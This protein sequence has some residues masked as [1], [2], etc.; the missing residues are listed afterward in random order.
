MATSLSSNHLSFDALL[1]DRA[2]STKNSTVEALLA[3]A[4]RK[5]EGSIAANGAFA[6][7]TGVH[8][9]RS[10]KDK[11][12][13]VD[14]ESRA[15]V[16]WGEINQ[17]M[18]LE[19]F[20]RLGERILAHLKDKEVFVEDLRAGAHP[21]Y[22]L[23][24]RL[25]SE[26]AWH[27][28]FAKQLFIGPENQEVQTPSPDF[29]V[30][31]APGFQ[32]DPLI[33]KVRSKAVI[34]I[35]FRAGLILIGG[36]HYA[37]EI[38]KSIFTV[39]NYLL[40]Q[41]GVLPMHCSANRRLDGE[42]ALFFG[43]SGTGKTTLSADPNRHLIGDDEHGWSDAGIF[44]FEGG[45]YAKCIHLSKEREPQIWNAIRRGAVLE[46]VVL[47]KTSKVPNYDDDSI[48]ENTRAAYPLD[49]IN[50]AVLPSV[51]GHPKNIFFLTAD[52]FGVLPPISRLT[53]E[54]AMYHFLCGYT[55]K[56]AGTESGLGKGPVATFSTCFGAPFLPLRPSQY[57]EM[58]GRR[59]R[60][61]QCECWLVNT[62]WIGG[63]Y[64]VGER[65]SLSYPR[66]LIKAVL[67]GL[68]LCSKFETERV[69]RLS[70][71]KDC[72]EVPSKLLHP[73]Q[74][75][76]DKRAYDR[77]AVALATRFRENAKAVGIPHTFLGGGPVFGFGN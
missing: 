19:V 41:R 75:W 39:L 13:V 71:P 34:A 8:T 49:F 72:P 50:N 1:E 67:S 44:N 17:A 6:A 36:T 20:D 12:I 54:Q 63:Q 56:I 5:G 31:V 11:F 61:H 23:R 18:Q 30:V 15:R 25:I 37:G 27:A 42:T 32:A 73:R 57:A 53:A 38:K 69:F 10:P 55:S 28:L 21:T 22:Q 77:T 66:A 46:N 76:G 35:N 74:N 64:G 24:V 43:L 52:A 48:T 70:I 68:A 58:L 29:T 51:G 65:I 45:C 40:P 47:D 9:G 3:I 62:G 4:E 2:K 14:D 59:I 16:A 60:E 26:F 7:L 33:D